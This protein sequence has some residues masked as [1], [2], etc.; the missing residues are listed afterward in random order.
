[1]LCTIDDLEG[2]AIQAADGIIGHV[3]DLYFDDDAWGV[4]YLVVQTGAWLI[5]RKVLI[6]PIAITHPNWTEKTL[7]VSMT[8]EQVAKS[9]GLD[10]DKPVSRQHEISH[11]EYY[12]HPYYWG[13][14]DLS[15]RGIFLGSDLTGVGYGGADAE[16]QQMQSERNREIAKAAESDNYDTHLRSCKAVVSYH[17]RALDGDLGHVS[18]LLV[19]DETWTIRYI[20]VDTSN[21]WLGRQVL[22]APHWIQSVNWADATISVNLSRRSIKTAPQYTSTGVLDQKHEIVGLF[23]HDSH[24]AQEISHK[25]TTHQTD[26]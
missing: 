18:G 10:T 8:K 13:S 1:M 11:L 22:I 2:Y 12:H 17:I 25:A 6:S 24:E 7:S 23:N 5:G 19:D 15:A 9:P 20:I 21:W 4:R 14:H 3:K 16:Y 26:R